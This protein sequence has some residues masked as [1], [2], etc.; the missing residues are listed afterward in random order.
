[1]DYGGAGMS[2]E[3]TAH[4]VVEAG[5]AGVMVGVVAL[6]ALKRRCDG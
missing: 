3:V 2:L 1:M 6:M 4:V 5:M